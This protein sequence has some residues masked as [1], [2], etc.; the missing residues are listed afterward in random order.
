MP[1]KKL[2][3][4]TPAKSKSIKPKAQAAKPL[5]K[6]IN[7]LLDKSEFGNLG[8]SAGA[9]NLVKSIIEKGDRTFE[10]TAQ[11]L[12]VKKSST[13]FSLS[14]SKADIV[15]PVLNTIQWPD[16]PVGFEG[17]I[18]DYDA[19]MVIP[20]GKKILCVIELQSSKTKNYF[21]VNFSFNT[22]G[23]DITVE[24]TAAKQKISF[25]VSPQQTNLGVI[26]VSLRNRKSITSKAK[27]W[28]LFKWTVVD[29]T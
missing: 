13:T 3:L 4:V 12:L 28:T 11:Q 20:Q 2:P 19:L 10:L 6:P 1:S 25:I 22:E 23:P 24:S 8:L 27:A 5:L 16:E 29:I 21:N 18:S 14:I 17:P 9:L 15:N 26:R 7:D